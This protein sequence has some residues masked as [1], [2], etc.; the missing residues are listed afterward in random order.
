[1]RLAGR[2]VAPTSLLVVLVAAP[3]PAQNVLPRDPGGWTVFAPSTDT[4]IHYVSST[5]GDDG[6]A[7][8]YGP[9]SPEVGADPFAPTGV[10]RPYRT[11][12]AASNAA[13]D[14]YPDWVLLKRGDT[15]YE[16]LRLRNG[17]ADAEPSVVCSYGPG[18]ERPTLKTDSSTAIRFWLRVL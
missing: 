11:V 12:A 16:T 6:T 5:E 13:R 2:V 15:W 4:R 17:R 9:A 10:V 1:M 18:C 8:W 3:V 14:G 7:T